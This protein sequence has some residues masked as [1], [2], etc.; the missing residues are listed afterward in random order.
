VSRHSRKSVI[1]RSLGAILGLGLLVYLVVRIGPSALL[2]QT[3]AV[4]WGMLLIL[5]LGGLSHLIKACAWRLTL[6]GDGRWIPIS[7]AFALRLISEAAGQLGL[8][9]QVLGEGI[10]VSLLG[11]SVSADA[12][13]S[14]A[15]IDRGLYVLS[16][17][18]VGIVGLI[19]AMMLLPLSNTWKIYT[20]AF[21]GGLLCFVVLTVIAVLRHWPVLSAV[22][23]SLQR[24]PAFRNRLVGT[25]QTIYLAEQKL[26]VFH[27][28]SPQAFW[29]SLT[30]NLCSQL[31][32]I[33]EVY[34]LV[35]F[36][37]SRIGFVSAFVFEG[38]TKLVNTVG[39]LVPGNVGTYEGGS[40]LIAK[41]FHITSA[42]G[43]SVGICRR[44]RGLFWAAIGMLCLGLV[45]RPRQ[46][47]NIVYM[48]V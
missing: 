45:S 42:V 32:A 3:L 39:A 26:L 30:L 48:G 11:P 17:A 33:A 18:L 7:R 24:L 22:V 15:T 14:S 20:M 41:L 9:G 2:Q 1:V 34:L 28:D 47:P 21:C 23:R 13:I 46:Q 10:R 6:P 29:I 25:E 5:A 27:R 40:M 31:L 37:G 36:M 12:G 43:F 44:I 19:G 38:F 4:G 8:A 16:S 35:F